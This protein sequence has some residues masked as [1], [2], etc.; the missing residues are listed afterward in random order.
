MTIFEPTK[1]R[2]QNGRLLEIREAKVQD[3]EAILEYVERI[4]GE[5]EYLTFGPGEF[6]LSVIE[7]E[8]YLRNCHQS[9]N[10][11]YIIGLVGDVIVGSLNFAAGRRSRV[12][13]S[14]E[15]G[16]SVRKEYWGLGIGSWM[17][18]ALIQW[19]V[20]GRVV[21]K[22]NLR[23]RTDNHQAIHLYERKGFLKEGTIRKEIFLDGR[24]L[25]HYWMGL[26]V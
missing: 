19:A 9:D 21:K 16:M 13:H 17:L 8:N 10:Q 7:E 4:S 25:D 5:S 15:F 24:Y 23:V 26:E 20:D 18:D 22:I 6:E 11:V 14:G 3:A 12:R 1:H 2:I